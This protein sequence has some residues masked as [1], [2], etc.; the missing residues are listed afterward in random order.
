MSVGVLGVLGVGVG[1]GIS[2]LKHLLCLC[3]ACPVLGTL[4]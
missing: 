2:P 3:N 1:V 4:V